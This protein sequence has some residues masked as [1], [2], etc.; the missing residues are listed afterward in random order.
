MRLSAGHRQS[1]GQLVFN[2]EMAA[3]ESLIKTI[4][5]GYCTFSPFLT[6]QVL[7]AF[8]GEVVDGCSDMV[9]NSGGMDS[10]PRFAMTSTLLL[11]ENPTWLGTHSKCS[12]PITGEQFR[13]LLTA[14]YCVQSGEHSVL[15]SQPGNR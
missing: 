15:K 7:E 3:C 9:A 10:A 2:A 4:L 14:L 8:A 1:V 12:G 5:R 13:Q 11:P 6:A